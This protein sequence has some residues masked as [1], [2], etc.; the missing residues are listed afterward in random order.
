MIDVY[1]SLCKA[2]DKD[3]EPI[4]GPERL[5][6]IKHSNADVSKLREL[7]RSSLEFRQGI[8]LRSNGIRKTCEDLR[9]WVVSLFS[10]YSSDSRVWFNLLTNNR[11]RP[12]PR[13][14]WTFYL[15]CDFHC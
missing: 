14:I 10:S 11:K 1:Y 12:R 6:D 7:G 3:I 15:L 9:F 5:G 2:L 4:F 13:W 8:K